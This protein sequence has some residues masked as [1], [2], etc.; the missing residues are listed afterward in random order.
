MMKARFF[1][2]ILFALIIILLILIILNLSLG[3][4]SIPLTEFFTNHPIYAYVLV[5][6][7]I[8]RLL[9][10]FFSGVAL[11]LSGSILQS[12]SRNDLADPGIIGINAGAGLGVTVFFLIFVFEARTFAYLLPVVAFL[13]GLLS[14]VVIFLLSYHKNHGIHPYKMILMGVGFS[15]AASG[16]MVLLISSAERDQVAFITNWLAGNVWGGDWPYVYF[17]LPIMLVLMVYLVFQ[18]QTLNII[19]LGDQQAKSLGVALKK[20]VFQYLLVATMLASISVALVG[21]IS[22]IG[23]LAPHIAKQLVGQRN[24]RFLPLAAL[25]GGNLLLMAD[26]LARNIIQ[27]NGLPTGILVA[28]I[29]AP[30]FIYLIIKK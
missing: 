24:Q 17:T 7:R 13:G 5:N 25:I 14:A 21:N 22:F 16:L 1:K 8:P 23:L 30:Y 18:T 12:I 26:L 29:G 20:K 11:A 15:M 19:Q 6:I 3:Q 27:P 9:V 2:R 28:V 4:I 10:V